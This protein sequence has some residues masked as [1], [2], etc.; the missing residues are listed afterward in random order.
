MLG[1]KLE[2]LKDKTVSSALRSTD[3]LEI[4]FM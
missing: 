2:N 4:L 1:E 3:H